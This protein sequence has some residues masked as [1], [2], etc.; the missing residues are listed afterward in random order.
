MRFPPR[1]GFLNKAVLAALLLALAS[2][3]V[4]TTVLQLTFTEVCDRAT[5]IF[6][7]KVA[8]I[9]VRREAS[10][11]IWTYV[12]WDVLDVVKGPGVGDRIEFP[13]LGGT[14]GDLTLEVGAMQ[15]PKIGEQGIYFIESLERR[16]VQP[17]LGWS[18][19][20]YLVERD[21]GGTRRILTPRRRP[22]RS[23]DTEIDALSGISRGLARGIVVGQRGAMDEALAADA[24]KASIRQSLRPRRQ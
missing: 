21:A 2:T 10:G 22:V 8:S 24:F 14:V 12:T 11:K 5:L 4:A 6:E 7:G 15:I 13:F 3:C 18:Q 20:H 9:E 1:I 19:G 17:L 23:I 16:H